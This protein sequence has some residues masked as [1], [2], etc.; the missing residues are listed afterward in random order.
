MDLK[1]RKYGVCPEYGATPHLKNWPD[2]GCENG[3][4]IIEE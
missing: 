3:H 1:M 4:I 2:L